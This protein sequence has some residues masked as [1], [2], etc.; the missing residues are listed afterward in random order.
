[1]GLAA[2]TAN[3]SIF[4]SVDREGKITFSDIPVDGAVKTQLIASSEGA[5]PAV[6]E[7]A[8]VYLALLDGFDES[9]RQAN[10]R[11]DLAE[12]SLAMA[13]RS[14]IAAEDTHGLRHARPT[15]ADARLIEFYKRDVATARK[16]LAKVLQQRSF[17]AAQ[18]RP[19]A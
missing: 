6:G 13:R 10:A 12:H 15:E 19:L 7:N 4:K 17:Y 8:P 11:V 3:A 16:S 5:N 2:A 14:M 9:V 18:A 1:V